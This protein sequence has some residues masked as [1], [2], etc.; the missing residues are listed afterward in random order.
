MTNLYD[1]FMY[2]DED[3]ILDIR[4]NTLDQYVDKFIIAEATRN[5]AG[6]E[7]KLN[8]D[9]KNF[10]K[11]KDKIEY[12]VI[13]DIP[14]NIKSNKTN[15]HENHMRDQFQRNA[16][17]RG[18]DKCNDE[19]LIMI[20]D[21]D[22]IPDP[23]KIKDFIIKNKYACFLQKNF[24]SKLNL[25]NITNEYWMGTKICQKKFLKS[26]QW[27]RDIKIKER[28]FWKF[29]KPKQPQLIFNGGWH[30]SF[31]K[32][33]EHIIKK[34][35]AYSHQEFNKVEFTQEQNI[36]QKI[37][38][39]EDLLGR[40]ISYKKVEINEKFPDYIRDNKVKFKDWIL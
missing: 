25:I 20:S 6:E 36:I 4:L 19:D 18:F 2:F 16:L 17:S 3:L 22:E 7:K 27:L 38:I 33:P 15:W 32:S 37:R 21:I 9:F 13:D 8:F 5:H 10:S 1:C 28:P 30:F 39:H 26:P 12:L 35:K 23:K 24:Q 14:K 40:N 11:F 31:L 34:I 29:Y